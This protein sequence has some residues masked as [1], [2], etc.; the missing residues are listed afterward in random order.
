MLTNLMVSAL[1][2]L[3]LGLPSMA[4]FFVMYSGPCVSS[5]VSRLHSFLFR[6]VCDFVVRRGSSCQSANSSSMVSFKSTSSLSSILSSFLS[7]TSSLPYDPYCLLFKSYTSKLES[8]AYGAASKV[9]P[10]PLVAGKVSLPSSTAGVPLLSVLPPEVACR[11]AS[12]SHILL[13]SALIPSD[14]PRPS[15]NG[16]ALQYGLLLKRLH[17]SGMVTFT[18][19]PRVVNGVFCVPKDGGAALRLIVDARR[20]NAHFCPPPKVNLPTPHHLAHLLAAQDVPLFTAKADISDYYHQLLLPEWL[21]PFFALPPVRAGDLGLHAYDPDEMVHPC[22][23][24]LPMGWSHAVLL[25]QHAHEFLLRSSSPLFLSPKWSVSPWLVNANSFDAYVDDLTLVGASSEQARLMLDSAL[26]AYAECS[27]PVKPSKV[28]PPSSDAKVLLGVEV[29]GVSKQVR[30]SLEACLSLVGDTITLLEQRLVSGKQLEA[31]VG[32]WTWLMLVRRPLLS[33]FRSV[34]AFIRFK[35]RK[36]RILW[37]SA[38]TELACA[39]A[40][41]PLM[42]TSLCAPF[43]EKVI[44]T[45]A[46][47]TGAGVAATS[48]PL[49]RQIDLYG[50]RLADPRFPSSIAAI[51]PDS[52]WKPVISHRFTRSEHINSLE[53][54]AVLLGIRWVMS[55][56]N[57]MGSKVHLLTDS[58]VT[59]AVLAKGRTSAHTIC[60]ISRRIAAHLLASGITLLPSWIP[61]HLNPADVLSRA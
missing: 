24:T 19:T 48:M 54:Q 16:C 34:Y 7:N 10:T 50:L 43:F 18:T 47:S 57:G 2:C 30:P 26:V 52:V 25:A 49:Q 37:P 56:K 12:P 29:D 53:L 11:Y 1:N 32:R 45:D 61:T 35:G 15:V 60:T 13:D 59:Q 6:A 44:A 39:C 55:S 22:V 20:A 42:H 51:H 23:R 40:L 41:V 14:L 4:P 31:L 8:G 33:V 46:S 5:V 58:M 36:R 9:G 28:L 38:R 27:L 3:S 21:V 17:A